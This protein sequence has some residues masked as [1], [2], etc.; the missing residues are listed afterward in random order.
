MENIL[1]IGFGYVPPAEFKTSN[2][3]V[4]P[5][6]RTRLRKAFGGMGIGSWLE[7]QLRS[8]QLIYQNRS[9]GGQLNHGGGFR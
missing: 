3:V 4:C 6:G 5:P 2:V 8:G 1:D 7:F 9:S